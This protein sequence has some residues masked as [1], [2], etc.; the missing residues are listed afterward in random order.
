[1]HYIALLFKLQSVL[2]FKFTVHD[3]K[4]RSTQLEMKSEKLSLSKNLHGSLTQTF[5]KNCYLH[6]ILILTNKQNNLH[7]V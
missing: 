5:K 6:G 2:S 7:L 3:I 1:M 4:T